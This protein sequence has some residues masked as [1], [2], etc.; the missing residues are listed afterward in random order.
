M[1][2]IRDDCS[3]NSAV[4]PLL[5]RFA[6][7][8][9]LVLL[10]T[11]SCAQRVDSRVPQLA[12][13]FGEEGAEILYFLCPEGEMLKSLQVWRNGDGDNVIGEEG[14]DIL[15]LD[16]AAGDLDSVGFDSGT[17]ARVEVPQIDLNPETLFEL[18]TDLGSAYFL[19]ADA[20]EG[21]TPSPGEVGTGASWVST[22]RFEEAAR[23]NCGEG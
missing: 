15:L 23:A 1:P 11:A 12:I 9:A 13:A 8:L 3:T 2:S 19:P 4:R 6:G 21:G 18:E 5:A 7:S 20:L 16:L 17:L 14:V 10:F 22:D